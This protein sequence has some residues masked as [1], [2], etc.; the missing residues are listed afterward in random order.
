MVVLDKI[1]I[2]RQEVILHMQLVEVVEMKIHN[3]I[4]NLLQVV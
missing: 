2:M 1:I 3:M 4:V